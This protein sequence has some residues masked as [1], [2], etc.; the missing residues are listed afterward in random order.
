MKPI[1][2]IKSKCPVGVDQNSRRLSLPQ[3]YKRDVNIENMRQ[4]VFS[5]YEIRRFI[6]AILDTV[7][8]A[9]NWYNIKYNP[10]NQRKKSHV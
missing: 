7:P 6:L 5:L 4:H 9:I 10:N 8:F 2:H 1:K 3:G